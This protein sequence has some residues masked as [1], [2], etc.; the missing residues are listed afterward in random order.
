MGTIHTTRKKH[1]FK[2]LLDQLTQEEE[3]KTGQRTTIPVKAKDTIQEIFTKRCR[4]CRHND[5]WITRGCNS[6][7]ANATKP[8]ETTTKQS[9]SQQMNPQQ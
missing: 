9:A 2:N 8:F 3:R 7:D 4:S 1:F 6:N 5:Y